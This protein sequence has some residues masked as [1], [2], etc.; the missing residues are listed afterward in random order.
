MLGK[1]GHRHADEVDQVSQRVERGLDH[2]DLPH[3]IDV[4]DEPRHFHRSRRFEPD[5]GLALDESSNSTSEVDDPRSRATADV[6]WR[7]R[8]VNQARAGQG[9]ND[10]AYP[11]EIDDLL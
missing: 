9:F 5:L 7:E 2:Q 3:A 1:R 10:L 8:T 4:R 11:D 6:D